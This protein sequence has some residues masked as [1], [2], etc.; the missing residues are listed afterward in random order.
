M[1]D[2]YTVKKVLP[3]L[4]AA[5]ILIQLSWFIFTGMLVLTTA[6]AYG[7]GG[8]MAAPFGGINSLSLSQMISDG[9]LSPTGAGLGLATAAVVGVLA[10]GGVVALGIMIVLALFVGFLTLVMRKVLLIALLL[11]SPVALV[12]WILPGTER[13]WKIWWENFSKLLLMFPLIVIM[14][15]AGR[16]FAKITIGT[17]GAELDFLNMVIVIIAVFAPIALIPLT[18]KAAGAGL[19]AISGAIGKYPSDWT[20][21]A[22][23]R[24]R[25]K[26]AERMAERGHRAS[27]GSFFRGGNEHNLRGRLNRGIGTTAH[28]GAAGVRPDKWRSRIQAS[29]SEAAFDHA[30]EALEKNSAMRAIKDNDTLLAAAMSGQGNES[31][32]RSYLASS[33]GGNLTGRELEQNVASVMRAKR[34]VGDHGFRIASAMAMAGTGT[35]YGE[36]PGE[37]LAAL[38][39]AA[40]GDTALAGRMLA[41][42]R[43]NAQNAR[44]FDLAGSGFGSSWGALQDISRNGGDAASQTRANKSLTEEA[45]KVQGAGAVLGGR[46]TSVKNMAPAIRNRITEA[47]KNVA[48]ASASG[49][50][51][52]L[53]AAQRELKQHLASTAGLLDVAGQV[54]PEN[55]QIL[56][57]EVMSYQITDPGS[58]A[59]ATV[60]SIVDGYRSDREFGEMRREYGQQSQAQYNSAQAA[61]AAAAQQGNQANPIAPPPG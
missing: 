17:G 39:S 20:N 12:A 28:L 60:G 47:V 42:A 8:L 50:Q 35:G 26:Q 58:G 13:F 4:V 30:T 5:V 46:G 52:A 40:D 18:Y 7:I 49:D 6:V 43:G 32:I 10:A 11:L 53:A 9:G 19:G 54:S 24:G 34:E 3:R 33:K 36:G 2:A 55:A 31:D 22:R 23:D 15:T 44:R 59:V 45:I 25:K 16:I 1:F 51:A 56:A 27:E 61:A 21:R 14:L 48:S 41:V 57:D 38:N 37:M 29:Q